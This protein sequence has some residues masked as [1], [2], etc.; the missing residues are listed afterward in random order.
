ML[1]YSNL[2]FLVD[3]IIKLGYIILIGMR[4]ILTS[5]TIYIFKNL[6]FIFDYLHHHI[7]LYII[8]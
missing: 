2:F 3:R 8:I 7:I 4:M 6:D 1:L 5:K